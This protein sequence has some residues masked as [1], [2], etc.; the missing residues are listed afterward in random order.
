MF[1]KRAKNPSNGRVLEAMGE[2]AEQHLGKESKVQVA[3][4]AVTAKN[5]SDLYQDELQAV[6]RLRDMHVFGGEKK[7]LGDTAFGDLVLCDDLIIHP[8]QSNGGGWIKGALIGAALAS[9]IGGGALGLGLLDHLL[10]KPPATTPASADLENEYT[11]KP[12]PGR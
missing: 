12:L 3:D 9:G 7:P 10:N 6:R 4:Q 8:P 1:G 2:A 11:I 5:M